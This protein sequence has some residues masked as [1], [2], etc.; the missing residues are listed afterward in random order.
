MKSKQI[1]LFVLYLCG[2]YGSDLDY[3]PRIIL[4]GVGNRSMEP[5]I[6]NK[7]G[8]WSAPLNIY[9]SPGTAFGQN[10]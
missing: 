1:A 3:T 2:Y 9:F 5:K 6:W 4:F 10:L 8:E 7:L